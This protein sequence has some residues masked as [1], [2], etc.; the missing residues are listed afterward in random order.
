M[1]LVLIDGTFDALLAQLRSAELDCIVGALRPQVPSEIF[2]QEPLFEDRLAV[3]ARP[4]HPLAQQPALVWADLASADWV[5]PMPDTP[6]QH[7][8]DRMVA[9]TG[10][11]PPRAQVRANSAMLMQALVQ[12]SDR[13]ALMSPRQMARELAHGV[14]VELPLAVPQGQRTIGMVWRSDYLP[15]PAAQQWQILLRQVVHSL[16]PSSVQ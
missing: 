12:D 1:Q 6:A 4:G 3:V 10:L 15:T 8:F 16:Q 14:L 13:L 9:S 11:P 2:R 7:A 5:M